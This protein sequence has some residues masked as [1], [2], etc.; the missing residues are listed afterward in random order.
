VFSPRTPAVLFVT[1]L[2]AYS[3]QWM[4]II[5]HLPTVTLG[6]EG[7][8]RPGAHALVVEAVSP[9][10]PADRA[11]LHPGD[12]VTAID[13]HPLDTSE[14]YF[15]LRRDARPRTPVH[16]AVLHDGTLRD[17]LLTPTVRPET[18]PGLSTWTRLH[19]ERFFEQIL[20]LYPLPFLL[21]A[22]VVLLQRPEDPHAWLLALML[23][24]FIALAPMADFEFRLPAFLRGPT[25]ALWVLLSVPTAAVTTHSSASFQHTPRS[26]A[27]CP[28]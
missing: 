23:G 16:L 14:P 5:R 24:G 7:H 28:G 6:L 13:G 3:A 26:T 27:V 12:L 17:Y 4:Y 18:P 8:L 9:E 1:L 19:I 15:A 25:L 21:V 22:A 2:T 20:G 10:G 11:G